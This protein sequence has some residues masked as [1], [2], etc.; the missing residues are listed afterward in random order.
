MQRPINKYKLLKL[1]NVLI[2]QQRREFID[3]RAE[4]KIGVEVSCTSQ[5]KDLKETRSSSEI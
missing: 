5:A 4:I 1:A 3:T 2:N